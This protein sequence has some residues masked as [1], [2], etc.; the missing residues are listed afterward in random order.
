[1][2]AAAFPDQFDEARAAAPSKRTVR[3]L[4][5]TWGEVNAEREA[6]QRAAEAEAARKAAAA[7]SLWWL[8][9]R[10]YERSHGS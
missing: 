9:E 6:A 7:A 8:Q 1:M 2:W 5:V 10:S 3:G 4:H